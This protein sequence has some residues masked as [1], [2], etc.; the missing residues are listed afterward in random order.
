M[1]VLCSVS[2]LTVLRFPSVSGIKVF[3]NPGWRFLW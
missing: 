3:L 1:V 2:E